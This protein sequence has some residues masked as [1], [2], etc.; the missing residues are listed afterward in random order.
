MYTSEQIAAMDAAMVRA[1]FSMM[2][3]DIVTFYGD[4]QERVPRVCPGQDSS[5]VLLP[6]LEDLSVS[7]TPSVGSL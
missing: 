7:V 2:M 6:G 4:D 3:C 5:G 1:D